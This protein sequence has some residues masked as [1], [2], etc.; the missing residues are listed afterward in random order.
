MR[1]PS[2]TVHPRVHRAQWALARFGPL[3]S[4]S[5]AALERCDPAAD[6]LIE[7][8]ANHAD[9]AERFDLTTAWQSASAALPEP[10]AALFEAVRDVPAWVEWDRVERARRLFE[11]TGM[12]GGFVLSLRALLGGYVAP[13]G[14]K[15]LSFSGRLR[16]QA[17]RRVAE[18]ARF[19]TAVCGP[20]GMQPGAQGWLITLHVRLMHAQ[21]RRLLWASGR[22]DRARWA[23][24]IN[25][26]DMLATTLLFSEVY[27]EGLRL[28]GFDVSEREREDWVHLWKLVGWVMGTEAEL[29]PRDYAEAAAL[30]ELIQCTQGPPDDDSRALTAALLGPPPTLPGGPTGQLAKLRGGMVRGLSRMLI[31]DEVADQ[32]GIAH[33]PVWSL[34]L[35]VVPELVGASE[36]ARA[37]VPGVETQL[38]RAGA[39]YWAWVVELSLQGDPARFAR[40]TRL[41]S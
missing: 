30:R 8:L 32:L 16:E 1:E 9:Q 37:R 40:P 28:F 19:V 3:A 20:G 17:P 34:L 5:F 10:V 22:W 18:T 21:V 36:W 33:A 6:T 27:V 31:G 23:M 39:R 26:H 13:A 24:P 14:N 41:S 2:A 25:Q 38:R 11:R 7:W 4:R 35:P 15:P 29:L 12:F